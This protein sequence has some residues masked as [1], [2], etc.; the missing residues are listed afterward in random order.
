MKLQ[1]PESRKEAFLGF[2]KLDAQT[3]EDFLTSLSSAPPAFF[4]EDLA[5][6]VGEC[7]DVPAGDVEA[8]LGVLASLYQ[9]QASGGFT[10]DEL[11]DKVVDL[12]KTLVADEELATPIEWEAVR[13]DLAVAMKMDEP[14]GVTAKALDLATD[15]DRLLVD[16]RIIT[17]IRPVF[18]TDANDR[19]AAAV[20]VHSLRISYSHNRRME[21]MTFALDSKDLAAL[22]KQLDRACVK[23]ETLGELLGNAKLPVLGAPKDD[24]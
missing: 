2:L 24:E 5:T 18:H 9:T 22:K 6:A 4:L 7:L 15:F 11:A 3:R 19:P 10:S 23:E 1:I 17:D 16:A 8:Y 13:R 12:G 21:E 14:L 20:V